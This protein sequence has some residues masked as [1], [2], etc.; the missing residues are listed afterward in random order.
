M[1]LLVLYLMCSQ[2][3][4]DSTIGHQNLLQQKIL[5]RDIST[6]ERPNYGE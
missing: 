1:G 4:S 2:L 6:R 5:H 3:T